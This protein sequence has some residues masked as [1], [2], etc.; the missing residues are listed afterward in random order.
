[1]RYILFVTAVVVAT[2]TYASGQVPEPSPE[3][4]KIEDLKGIIKVYVA[5]SNQFTSSA[6][7]LAITETVRTGLPQIIFVSLSSRPLRPSKRNRN[8]II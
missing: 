1:M 6:T 7:T 4:G 3:K 8:E 2:F 5:T